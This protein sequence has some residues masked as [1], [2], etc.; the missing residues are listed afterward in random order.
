MLESRLPGGVE[1]HVVDEGLSLVSTA[2]TTDQLHPRAAEREVEDPCVRRVHEIE[3]YDLPHGRLAREVRLAVDQHDV[4]EPP[5]RGVVGAGAVE[6]R[7][8]TFLEEQ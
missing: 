5:H 6:G 3:A 7:D 8:V 2:V 4:A 1:H